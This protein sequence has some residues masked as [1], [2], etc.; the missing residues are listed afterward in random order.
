MTRSKAYYNKVLQLATI[1]DQLSGYEKSFIKRIVKN[2]DP[3]NL[4]E[5]LSDK[6]LKYITTLYKERKPLID[7]RLGYE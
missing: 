7:K 6:Q 4:Y 1:Y 3:N 2:A 5:E